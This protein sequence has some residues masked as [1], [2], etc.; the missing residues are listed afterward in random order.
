MSSSSLDRPVPGTAAA[1]VE[2]WL[3][4]WQSAAASSWQWLERMSAL[5]DP[6]ALRSWWL[7]DLRQLSADYLRSPGFTALMRLNLT[8]ITRPM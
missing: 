3:D 4:P 7:A 5:C 6:R 1:W 8:L 2:H